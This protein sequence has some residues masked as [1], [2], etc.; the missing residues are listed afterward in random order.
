MTAFHP[1]YDLLIAVLG[2]LS[3]IGGW[4]WVLRRGK[5]SVRVIQS[6]T[7]GI[8]NLLGPAGRA[9]AADDAAAL[10][11]LF[12]EVRESRAEAPRCDVLFLYCDIGPDGS[13]TH[14]DRRLR[15]I[16]RSAKA[17]IIVVASP[18]AA[19][20]CLEAAKETG[21]DSANLVLTLDRK[22]PA[23]ARFLGDLFA[24]MHAETAMPIAWVE[25]QPQTPD[26][27]RPENPDLVCLMERGHLAFRRDDQNHIP[28]KQAA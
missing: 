4:M 1:P 12:A 24:K 10:A 7:L 19:A 27:V 16:G 17:Q 26:A 20:D 14:S 22:G 5:D 13:I 28:T 25:L 23:F 15:E 11:H 2:G 6:P 18:N 21:T 8:L 9:W 3:A